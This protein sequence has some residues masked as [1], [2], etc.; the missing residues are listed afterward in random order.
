MRTTGKLLAGRYRLLEKLGSGGMAS[1][2]RADDLLLQVQCAVKLL[3]AEFVARPSALRRF[4]AEAGVMGLVRHINVVPVFDVGEHDGLPFIVMEVM[5]GGSLRDRINSLKKVGIGEASGLIEGVLSGLAAV[6]ARGVIHRDIKPANVLLD[7]AGQPKLTDFGIAQA[8]QTTDFHTRTGAVMGTLAYMSP[9]QRESA[10]RVGP[11]AD[12]YSVGALL[13]ALL[14]KR[15]P[16]DLYVVEK[17]DLAFQDFSPDLQIFLSKACA[18][19]PENRFANASEMQ[20]ALR[21]VV[22]GFDSIEMARPM[23]DEPVTEVSEIGGRRVLERTN[24]VRSAQ[25][26]VGRFGDLEAIHRWSTQEGSRLMS[27]VGPGGMGKSRLAKEFGLAHLSRYPGG[28][29]FVDLSE[30]RDMAGVAMAVATTLNVPLLGGRPEETVA[31]VLLACGKVLLI[32]DNLEQ[33]VDVASSMVAAWLVRAPEAAFLV[34]SRERMQIHG[35]QVLLLDALSND[36]A[37]E[38]LQAASVSGNQ[39]FS[40]SDADGEILGKIAGMLDGIPLA[41][42]LA[43]ARLEI[44]SGSDLLERMLIAESSNSSSAVS[45]LGLLKQ[46]RRDITAR[47]RSLRGAIDWSWNL[48]EEWERSAL[49]QCSVFSGG[50]TLQAA[51][52]VVDLSEY[53]EAP[54]TLQVIQSL[55]NQSL[56]AVREPLPE[57]RRLGLLRTIHAFARSHLEPSVGNGARDRMV[58]F[59]AQMGTHE[60]ALFGNSQGALA[61]RSARLELDNIRAAILY[62]GRG[63]NLEQRSLLAF[64]AAEILMKSGP[65]STGVEVMEGLL[66]DLPDESPFLPRAL[67]LGGWFQKRAGRLEVAEVEWLRCVKVAQDTINRAYSVRAQSWLGS[68]LLKRG[69]TEEALEMVK[70]AVKAAEALDNKGELAWALLELGEIQRSADEFDSAKL[71]LERALAMFQA[72]GD[73]IGEGQ[74]HAKLGEVHH[75]QG[76]RESMSPHYASAHS[77]AKQ[78][79]DRAALA[80]SLRARGWGHQECGEIDEGAVC[81]STGLQIARELGDRDLEGAFVGALGVIEAERKNYEAAIALCEQTLII[82]RELG[83][84]RREGQCRLNIAQFYLELGRFDEAWDESDRIEPLLD[85]SQGARALLDL[86]RSQ[87][88]CHR[89]SFDDA[90][91]L[92][93]AAKVVF[94]RIS[95]KE[96]SVEA[97][98]VIGLIGAASG[99]GETAKRCLVQARAELADGGFGKGSHISGRVEVLASQLD[100]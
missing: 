98:V 72:V 87:V 14:S 53:P 64:G 19:L 70:G 99:D 71:V 8:R 34:T 48:L 58:A 20:A 92:A 27:I 44:M 85:S 18:F 96:F 95:W 25:G 88:Q 62:V 51:E 91:T 39:T 21:V 82:G 69:Q 32:L 24:I 7:G 49:A 61:V 12:L 93:K 59:F 75:Y 73:R 45:F 43:A 89:G 74:C 29:W 30:A 2:F 33:V 23:I 31:N 37:I 42:E 26:F 28:V 86:I 1:V 22:T 83:D 52:A 55:V 47:H 50:F 79:N 78:M 77:I 94:D 10:A 16:Y 66:K 65:F 4:K 3:S 67:L 90:H 36:E 100:A 5:E 97:S 68:L 56:L 81:F 80:R 60:W 57:L 35:E 15:H 6:H 38:M 63:D 46:E 84:T 11:A 76:N 40:V 54:P 17:Q 9:E 13:F 41:L